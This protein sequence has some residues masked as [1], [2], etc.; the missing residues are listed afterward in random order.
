MSRPWGEV[1]EVKTNFV[2]QLKH[3]LERGTKGVYGIGTVTDP[4]QPLEKK[5]EIT[6][7]ALSLLKRSEAKIS[8]LTK[9]DLV[10]R[11]IDIL[12]SWPDVEVGVSLS[13]LDERL[14]GIIEPGAPSPERRLNA[15]SELASAGISTYLMAAPIIPCIDDSED[16]LKG[17]VRAARHASARTVMWDK[18]NHKPLALS[19]LRK[20]LAAHGIVYAGT[21]IARWQQRVGSVMAS[22]GR[23]L[24]VIIVDAF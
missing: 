14:A 24:G 2:Q 22:E 10:L 5:H 19:R 4:Y 9:S 8:I 17:I 15:L 12:R 21:D 6:R 16:E 1:V 23:S 20:T 18:F 11:D 7:G 3:E 13:C